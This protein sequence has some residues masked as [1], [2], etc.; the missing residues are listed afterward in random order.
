MKRVFQDLTALIAYLTIL[1]NITRFEITGWNL[2]DFHLSL[3]ILAGI[4]AIAI[5]TI[6]FLR[7]QKAFVLLFLGLVVYISMRLIAAIITGN[8][9]PDASQ[10]II[11]FSALSITILLANLLGHSLSD[12][13][14]VLKTLLFPKLNPRIYGEKGS[15]EQIA[16]YEFVRGR[17]NK[18]PISA[19]V[20]EPDQADR[21]WPDVPELQRAVEDFKK[22]Y[23]LAKLLN[24][25]SNQLRLSDLVIDMDEN[26]RFIIICPETSSE[27][28]L[29]LLKRLQGSAKQELGIDLVYGIASFPEDGQNLGGIREKA[30]S[31]LSLSH[32]SSS[33]QHKPNL[34]SG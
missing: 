13:E 1:F 16:N 5:I 3:F 25:V 21:T 7:H 18:R 26:G 34:K 20:I 2:I 8:N 11:E 10:A 31:N 24:I 28:S 33:G 29:V 30:E 22:K 9:Q 23:I 4:I 6:P 17:R 19:M 27:Q 12:V 32:Q 15:A 14:N